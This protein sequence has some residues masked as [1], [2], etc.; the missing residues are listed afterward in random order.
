MHAMNIKDY[1]A[2]VSTIKKEKFS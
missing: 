1:F 2:G